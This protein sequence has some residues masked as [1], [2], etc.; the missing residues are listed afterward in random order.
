MA[1]AVSGLI[2]LGEAEEVISRNRGQL[3][4]I[5]TAEKEMCTA[6]SGLGRA[7]GKCFRAAELCEAPKQ[8]ESANTWHRAE[9]THGGDRTHL[10]SSALTQSL[11]PPDPVETVIREVEVAMVTRDP[12]FISTL[13]GF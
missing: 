10:S 2:L 11:K 13:R 1:Y 12:A 6:G 4:P 7:E 3:V 9:T 5:S 8:A